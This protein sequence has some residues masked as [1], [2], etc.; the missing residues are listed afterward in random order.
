MKE[1]ISN[2]MLIVTKV[3]IV[4][5]LIQFFLQT[6]VNFW[7]NL[8]WGFR[9]II[10]LWKEILVFWI[11]IYG[12]K[13]YLNQDDKL[14][15]KQ[16]ITQLITDKFPLKTFLIVFFVT[17]AATFVVSLFTAD[18]SRYVLSIRYS[19]FGFFIFLIF[20]FIG[21]QFLVGKIDNLGNFFVKIMKWI[22]WL[23]LF[24]WLM[25]WIAPGSI[26]HFW[27]T[28]D[29]FEGKVGVS[30]PA[31]Y[32]TQ[33]K[34]G[35]VRNQFLFERPIN[36][37]FFLVALRP[38]FFV[39][40][41]SKKSFR[42][43]ILYTALFGLLIFS[44]ISRAARWARWLQTI[45]LYLLFYRK[46]LKKYKYLIILIIIPVL[47]GWLYMMKD[48]FLSRQYSDTG[49]VNE[50]NI[51]LNKISEKPILW[52]WPASAWPASHHLEVGKE[53]NPENQYL[54][55]RIEYGLLW[56]LGWMYLYIFLHII[57][58]KSYKE[59]INGN[60]SKKA[61]EYG[62]L[63]AALSLGLLWL[64]I[65]GLVLHSFV[66]RMIVYPFMAIFGI[67]YAWYLYEKK[68]ISSK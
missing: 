10:W 31:V 40:Y 26:T 4:G 30:P 48:K 35:F 55:I 36:F 17:L 56:F 58:Y 43:S 46:Y 59:V 34:T 37:G 45:I 60:H 61:K 68:H 25:L 28:L 67:I 2:I 33:Y 47:M 5:L 54:Q 14:N 62:I 8:Q 3:F 49:H 1:K 42:K 19:M 7:L 24:R 32:Y 20:F 16:K 27:Y 22:I 50:I 15:F 66:D 11:L 38:L 44:T 39:L 41:I 9:T 64:S 18:I 12:I 6:F 23:W 65:E 52:R 21:K 13:E 63:L 53:Y 57:G 29:S 51:A